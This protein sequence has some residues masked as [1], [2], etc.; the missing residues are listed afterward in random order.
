MVGVHV[1][2][3]PLLLAGSPPWAAATSAATAV[4]LLSAV[5]I[6]DR[7][8]PLPW[9]PGV[10]A[11]LLLGAATLLQITPLPLALV[12]WLSPMAADDALQ[13]AALLGDSAP[14]WVS[15][16][17][18][19]GR[20]R[21]SLMLG[22][23]V[24]ATTL[25]LGLLVERHRPRGFLRAIAATCSVVVLISMGHAALGATSVFGLYTPIVGSRTLG[26]IINLNHLGGFAALTTLLCLGLALKEDHRTRKTMAF[27]AAAAAVGLGLLTFSRGAALSVLLAAGLA[28][29][30]TKERSTPLARN[31]KALIAGVLALGL[32]AIAAIAAGVHQS[33]GLNDTERLDL[34][35]RGA[36]LALDYPWSGVGRGAF[37]PAF[38]YRSSFLAR[39]THPENVLLQYAIEFGLPLTLLA[40]ALFAR[41]TWRALRSRQTSASIAAAALVV[42]FAH[43]LFDFA[44]ELPGVAVPAAACAGIAWTRSHEARKPAFW[45]WLIAAGS[46]LALAALIVRLPQDDPAQVRARL[47]A[48]TLTPADLAEL[49]R[50]VL[51]Y[52]PADA[53]LTSRLGHA[54]AVRGERRAGRWLSRT[55]YLAPA[56]ADPH[57]LAAAWLIRLGRPDQALL[58]VR[59]AERR[60]P[61]SGIGAL[62]GVLRGEVDIDRIRRASVDPDTLGPMLE[63]VRRC[64]GS[65]EFRAQL[66]AAMVADG[67]ADA[68]THA[69]HLVRL[70]ASSPDAALAQAVALRDARPEDP[71]AVEAWLN[72]LLAVDPVAALAERE[73]SG[74]SPTL[75]WALV[76]VAVAE[77]ERE[78]V[79]QLVGTLR[80]EAAGQ[81]AE[82]AEID[83]RHGSSL[84]EMNHVE[85]GIQLLRSSIELDPRG[86]GA[87]SLL[88]MAVQRRRPGLARSAAVH[89]CS[90]H[91]RESQECR[92]AEAQVARLE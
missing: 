3:A 4:L 58:E 27:M 91:G 42:A 5:V 66:D 36:E 82:L 64:G 34:L 2:L 72:V 40:L 23:N 7:G 35:R 87:S 18:D 52:H 65:A 46:A 70:A 79:D 56:W 78:A 37:E 9:S 48:D 29:V 38:L 60:K 59:E 13:V 61:G 41:S 92:R 57:A 49:E 25:A 53:W 47:E 86:P 89:L 28:L 31:Q 84:C 76:R 21:M 26:P 16:S 39:Y 54:Y 83:A 43:D 63:R 17:R 24:L 22:I 90:Q 73:R 85:D 14:R 8:R 77:G 15:L 12:Q 33:A 69:R 51:L 10:A 88:R 30:V 50:D 19:P 6:A 1:G 68:A 32:A 62:C 81:S 55:M 80:T 74:L 75:R 11:L 20:T 67:S 71:P 45:V 44:L